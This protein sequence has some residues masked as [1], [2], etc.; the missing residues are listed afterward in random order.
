MVQK[1]ISSDL[2]EEAS[3]DLLSENDDDIV[4]D[5]NPDDNNLDFEEYVQKFSKSFSSFID[6]LYYLMDQVLLTTR[7]SLR[8]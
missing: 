4:P 2:A 8:F 5:P 6:C 7:E 1:L 3:D